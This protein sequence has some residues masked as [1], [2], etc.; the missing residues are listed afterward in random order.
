MRT[1]LALTDGLIP[2]RACTQP[3]P[4]AL[5]PSGLLEAGSADPSSGLSS[6]ALADGCLC[7]STLP[8][9]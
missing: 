5:H 3:P 9:A 6:P 7:E 2:M 1:C 4:A 8:A